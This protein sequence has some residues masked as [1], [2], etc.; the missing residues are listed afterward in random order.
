MSFVSHSF[1]RPSI[2][3]LS[4]D[5]SEIARKDPISY[6]YSSSS[7]DDLTFEVEMIKD[8]YQ[9]QYNKFHKAHHQ[10][11]K[12]QIDK[13]NRI[14]KGASDLNLILENGST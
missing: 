13:I 4:I 10:R 5:V 8:K 9:K 6:A 1:I 7:L 2:S 11:S 14:I 12:S 3:N